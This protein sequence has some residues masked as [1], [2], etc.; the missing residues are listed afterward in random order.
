M[1]KENHLIHLILHL[2]QFLNHHILL[3]QLGLEH[4]GF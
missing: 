2:I 4:L 3:I 1:K